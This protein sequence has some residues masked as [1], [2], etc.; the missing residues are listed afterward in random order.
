MVGSKL[1]LG[2]IPSSWQNIKKLA[3]DEGLVMVESLLEVMTAVQVDQLGGF[4]GDFKGISCG[5]QWLRGK[6]S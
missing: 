4:H 6:S 1:Y 2:Q 3:R 5:D